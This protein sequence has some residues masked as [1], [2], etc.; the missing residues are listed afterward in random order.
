MKIHGLHGQ[1][2]AYKQAK[3]QRNLLKNNRENAL[4]R[5]LR[6]CLLMTLTFVLRPR[7]S[8]QVVS[9]SWTFDQRNMRKDR[10]IA[11]CAFSDIL[12]M[13]KLFLHRKSYMVKLSYLKSYP[14]DF[15][16]LC[17]NGFSDRGFR[18]I[19]S[20][21][22]LFYSMKSFCRKVKFLSLRTI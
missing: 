22:S 10:E 7:S 11:E 4:Q 16:S 9:L 6:G 15:K 8:H 21:N 17:S 5:F 12:G 19:F 1:S 20:S 13:M 2:T 14:A 18:I 3:F